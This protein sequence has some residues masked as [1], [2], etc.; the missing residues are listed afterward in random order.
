[1]PLSLLESGVY[2]CVECTS[3]L[4]HFGDQ[5]EIQTKDGLDQKQNQI[6]SLLWILSLL[7]SYPLK[8]C[9]QAR[10]NQGPEKNQG[11]DW[12]RVS[13]TGRAVLGRLATICS[14]KSCTWLYTM[15]L[16]ISSHL[17]QNIKE[18]QG[19]I[20]RL[21]SLPNVLLS[22][23]FCH[24][25]CEST[26][27]YT[28]NIPFPEA[29]REGHCLL[30][31]HTPKLNQNKTYNTKRRNIQSGGQQ[32]INSFSCPST[33]NKPGRRAVK[34]LKWMSHQ[35]ENWL[36]PYNCSPPNSRVQSVCFPSAPL[37]FEQFWTS[38]SVPKCIPDL[39]ACQGPILYILH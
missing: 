28:A 21:Y 8:S 39:S 32:K 33:P 1:M 22:F 35:L 27:F 23:H 6:N 34:L 37:Q 17:S 19:E 10:E 4:I 5:T 26:I 9:A 29:H 16:F 31:P 36:S 25:P 24:S 12:S 38:P 13:C 14:P 3:E 20:T 30:W 15:P 11:C 2:V 18:L 7:C